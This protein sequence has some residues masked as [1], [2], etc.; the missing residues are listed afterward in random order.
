VPT[1]VIH[2]KEDII[3]DVEAGRY[4]AEKIPGAKYVELPGKDHLF[5]TGDTERVIEHVEEFVTGTQARTTTNSVLATVLFTDIVGSTQLAASLGDQRWRDL[6]ADF[7]KT[8][9][10]E[11][12]RF[13]GKTVDTIGDG[14]LATFDGP[15]RAIR[16]AIESRESVGQLGLKI[17]NGLHTGECELLDDKISGIAVHIGA[18]VVRE[19]RPGEVLVSSTVKDLVAG[20]KID[21]IERKA[22]KL[23][24]VP[25][26][27]KLYA[28]E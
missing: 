15:T 2:R 14:V 7:H 6:L 12:N 11:I 10:N 20:S 26:A 16:C 8:I 25:G 1:L 28:A 21:F 5:W 23:K 17:R 27:W 13:G 4:L 22:V 9:R 19:A 24:G 3:I 18:R